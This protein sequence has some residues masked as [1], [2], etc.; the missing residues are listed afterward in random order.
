MYSTTHLRVVGHLF[1]GSA[2]FARSDMLE[3]YRLLLQKVVFLLRFHELCK[4]T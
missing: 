1:V 4:N 2:N 3:V